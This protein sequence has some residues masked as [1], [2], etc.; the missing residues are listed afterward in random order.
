MDRRRVLGMLG[1]SGVLLSSLVRKALGASPEAATSASPDQALEQSARHGLPEDWQFVTP[2]RWDTVDESLKKRLNS[3][4]RDSSPINLGGIEV[5]RSGKIETGRLDPIGLAIELPPEVAGLVSPA[6]EA[7]SLEVLN[8]EYNPFL[9]E[10][11]DAS[12]KPL[13]GRCSR[14]R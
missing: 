1:V 2:A 6:D 7:L 4:L 10:P 8:R 3:V 9:A 5:T 14:S 13:V 11:R 12:G